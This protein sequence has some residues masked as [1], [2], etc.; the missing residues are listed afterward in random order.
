VQ[1]TYA[2]KSVATTIT[3]Q[4]IRAL[5]SIPNDPFVEILIPATE[6]HLGAKVRRCNVAAIPL[7][8]GPFALL[9]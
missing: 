2:S 5:N 9:F 6:Q 8:H 3:L 1:A 7:A 4:G